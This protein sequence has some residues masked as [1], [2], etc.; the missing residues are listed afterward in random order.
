MVEKGNY[1]KINSVVIFYLISFYYY[2]FCRLFGIGIAMT[3]IFTLLTPLF[4]KY[5]LYLLVTARVME[6]LFEGVTYPAMHA[7]W[8]RWAPPLERSKLAMISISGCYIGTVFSL[9]L[10][11]F[12]ADYLGWPSIFYVSG[13]S[14]T[15]RL[16]VYFIS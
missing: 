14:S 11:G 3:S 12:L 1:Y 8:S 4:T 6:G 9:P 10:S 13:V 15:Y 2:F 16:L 5:S 7:M